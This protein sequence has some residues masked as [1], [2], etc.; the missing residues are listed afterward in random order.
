MRAVLSRLCSSTIWIAFA[1]DWE[2]DSGFNQAEFST[3]L[4]K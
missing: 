1:L 4:R 3:G 2:W